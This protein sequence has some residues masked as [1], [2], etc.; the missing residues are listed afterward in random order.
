MDLATHA[1]AGLVLA[2]AADPSGTRPGTA[3]VLVVGSLLPDIDMV[4]ALFDP[5]RAPLLRHTATH[6]LILLPAM[7]AGLAVAVRLAGARA[8]GGHLFVL[9]ATG[10]GLHILLDLL[11]A[12]GVA[13]LFPLSDAR[14]EFGL[15]FVLDP[16]LTG[17]LVLALALSRLAPSPRRRAAVAAAALLLCVAYVDVAAGL[18]QRSADLV[19]ATAHAPL[20]DLVPEPLS[21]W[22]WRGIV[23]RPGGY[24]QY[25]VRPVAGVVT[26][27]DP[28]V[29]DERAAAVVAVRRSALP[30]GFD[31]FLR[32]PVWQVDG[33]RVTV[34]DLRYRFALLGNRWDPFGFAFEPAGAGGGGP[35]L[36]TATL[37]DRLDR[38]FAT[39]SRLSP[40]GAC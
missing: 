29:S 26:P 4:A 24:A 11:N 35:R 15:L 27:L 13:L 28:V 32:A 14:F 5:A 25:A 10:I 40:E 34:H 3:A 36:A 23:A 20:V 8:P 21:P 31:A 30:A 39:L 9:A 22:C 16:V 37:S 33:E 18:R 6:S 19:A 2:R 1:L 12:Y 7:A 17:I 38:A